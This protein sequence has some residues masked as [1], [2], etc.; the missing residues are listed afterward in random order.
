MFF[1]LSLRTFLILLLVLTSLWVAALFGPLFYS[2]LSPTDDLRAIVHALQGR[3]EAPLNSGPMVQQVRE[4][5]GVL[6]RAVKI[7]HYA[8]GS[9]VLRNN[10]SYTM[11]KTE[12]SYI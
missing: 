12:D 5:G 9:V 11:S 8:G 10:S 6:G 3:G 2:V 4:Q 7:G 1:K